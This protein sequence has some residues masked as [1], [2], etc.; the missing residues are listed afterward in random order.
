M[1]EGVDSGVFFARNLIV[2]MIEGRG[3]RLAKEGII[4]GGCR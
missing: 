2:S 4:G 1:K 3:I